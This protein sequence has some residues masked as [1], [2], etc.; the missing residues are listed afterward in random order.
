MTGMPAS[1]AWSATGVRASPSKGSST[2]AS[3]PSLMKV[4]T[5]LI[6]VLTSLVPSPTTSSTSSYFSASLRADSVIPAIQPWSLAG[7]EKAMRTVSPV[8]SLSLAALLP[9]LP[10]ELSGSLPVQ[11]AISAAAPTSATVVDR[12]RYPRCLVADMFSPRVS[13]PGRTPGGR[14]SRSGWGQVRWCGSGGGGLAC[15]AGPVTGRAARD[16]AAPSGCTPGT[17]GCREARGGCGSAASSEALTG[18][19]PHLQQDGEHDDHALGDRLR[20]AGQVVQREHVGECLEDQHAHHGADDRAAA[21]DEQ[22]AADDDGGDGIQLVQRAV[23]G[24]TRR[25][26][27]HQHDRGDAA[28]DAR[29]HVELHGV[30][31]HA[32][33]GEPGGL[34]VAADGERAPAERRAVQQHPAGQ[35]DEREDDHQ[36]RDAEDVA[37]EE[38][39]EVPVLDD[40]RALV[41]DDLGETAGRGE[42]RQGGDEGD[43]LAVGDDHAVDQPGAGA[44]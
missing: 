21:T 17:A 32:D 28:G 9:P 20:G 25:R 10:P 31:L 37:A 14:G 40:L 24:A 4:S 27:R 1:I 11:P 23:G 35:R 34:G 19:Q 39:E 18:R 7:A 8:S 29:Q 41:R 22:R 6:W 12:R 26:P 33:A 43:E 42:H 44:D 5:W 15:A 36:R 2:I 30:A 16:R 38:R 13:P 3:T